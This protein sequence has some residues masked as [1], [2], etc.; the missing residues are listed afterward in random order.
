MTLR[1]V[2]NEVVRANDDTLSLNGGGIRAT[3]AGTLKAAE[4]VAVVE[5]I[6]PEEAESPRNG[7]MKVRIMGVI[8]LALDVFAGAAEHAT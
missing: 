8:V 4:P 2:R 1:G 7:P 6:Q 5:R 3:A